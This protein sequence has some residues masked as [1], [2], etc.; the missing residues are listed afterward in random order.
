MIHGAK[1]ETIVL[2]FSLGRRREDRLGSWDEDDFLGAVCV[3]KFGKLSEL[4]V[5]SGTIR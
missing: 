3:E 1:L 4:G 2:G 5:D